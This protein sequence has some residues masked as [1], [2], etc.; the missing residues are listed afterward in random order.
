MTNT[1]AAVQA[2]YLYVAYGERTKR[3]GFAGDTEIGYTGHWNFKP[4]S[5]AKQAA[6]DLSLTWFRAYDP[7]RGVWLSRDPMGEK[8]GINA[9]G[10]VGNRPIRLTDRSGL[11]V[12]PLNA[13]P[14][15]NGIPDFIDPLSTPPLPIVGPIG[16]NPAQDLIYRAIM[17]FACCKQTKVDCLK[18]CDKAGAWYAATFGLLNSLN[19][20]GAI[21]NSDRI[22]KAVRDC[23]KNCK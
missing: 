18:C 1:V 9:Y 23:K 7:K 4:A 20:L 12:D 13:D 8:G 17:K 11:S 14:L 22:G 15:D 16:I 10:M 5:F 2:A 6:S 21:S 3:P 19:P